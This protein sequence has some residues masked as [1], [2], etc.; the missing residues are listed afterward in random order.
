MK[1]KTIKDLRDLLDD[2]MNPS[3]DRDYVMAQFDRIIKEDELD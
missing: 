2:S 3:C 1:G